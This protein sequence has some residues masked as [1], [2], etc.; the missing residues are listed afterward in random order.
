M[1]LLAHNVTEEDIVAPDACSM[2]RGKRIFNI[3]RERLSVVER[4]NRFHSYSGAHIVM[5]RERLVMHNGSSTTRY[6][7]VVL[8]NERSRAQAKN[9]TIS[10]GTTKPH[11]GLRCGTK[12]EPQQFVFVSLCLKGLESRAGNRTVDGCPAYRK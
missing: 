6:S 12:G 11:A 4:M 5:F 7:E 9:T 8:A 3:M 2:L 1:W 10:E